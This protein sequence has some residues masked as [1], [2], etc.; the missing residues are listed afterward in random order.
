MQQQKANKRIQKEY[1]EL[2][3]TPPDGVV[4]TADNIFNS[5]KIHLQGPANTPYSEGTFLIEITFPDNYPFKPPKAVFKT[6][7]YHPN[8][9]K[10]TGEICKDIYEEEWKPTKTI[11][12]VIEILKS[13]L[14]A[15]N[16]DTPLETEIA[17][18]YLKDRSKYDATAKEWTKKYASQ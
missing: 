15:P 18:E 8:I 6:T 4:V 14:I 11:K 12:E 10:D 13:M 16:T 2:T 17:T 1:D 7:T 3:K 5:W 9:K